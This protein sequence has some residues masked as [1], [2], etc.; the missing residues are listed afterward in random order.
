MARVVGTVPINRA[1]L[2]WPLDAPPSDWK[3][4]VEK[5]ERFHIVG[6]WAAVAAFACFLQ[7]HVPG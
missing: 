4:R 5:A 7:L 3:M 1:T 6:T 2:E